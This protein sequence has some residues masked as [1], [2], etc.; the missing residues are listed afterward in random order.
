[1]EKII[2]K[3]ISDFKLNKPIKGFFLC[4]KKCLKETVNGDAFLDVRLKDSTGSI[5]AKLWDNIEIYDIQFN[6]GDLVAVK[7]I[8]SEFRQYKYLNILSIKKINPKIYDEYGFDKTIIVSSKLANDEAWKKIDILIKKIHNSH[9]KELVENIFIKNRNAIYSLTSKY[10]SDGSS[11]Y[12]LDHIE[13]VCTIVMKLKSYYGKLDY[14]LIF[15]CCMLYKIGLIHKNDH[16]SCFDVNYLSWEIV[17]HQIDKMNVFNNSLKFKIR[18]IILNL[19]NE[20]NIKKLRSKEALIAFY[21]CNLDQNL[22]YYKNN[23]FNDIL[24]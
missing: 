13:S 15:A 1:M 23:V 19:N 9:L 5:N 12:F 4:I 18:D 6:T 22:N 24:R 7:G 17:S 21:I 14:D 8:V 10:M 2:L 20:N 11:E 3:K 16:E